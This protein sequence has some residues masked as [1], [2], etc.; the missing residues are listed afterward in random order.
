MG[1]WQPGVEE[2]EDEHDREERRDSPL[3]NFFN[4]ARARPRSLKGAGEKGITPEAR[5]LCGNVKQPK[6]NLW[7]D[8]LGQGQA[9]SPG[10]GGASPYHMLLLGKKIISLPRVHR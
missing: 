9:G 4:R 2:I 7:V 10:S 5:A 8:V 1:S 3:F 6:E